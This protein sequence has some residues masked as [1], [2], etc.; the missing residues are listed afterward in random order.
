MKLSWFLCFP[1]VKML[2]D[3]WSGNVFSCLNWSI[4]GLK[5]DLGHFVTNRNYKLLSL[6]KWISVG[7]D[8]IRIEDCNVKESFLACLLTCTCFPLMKKMTVWFKKGRTCG[9]EFAFWDLRPSFHSI[10]N[11]SEQKIIWLCWQRKKALTAKCWIRH[12]IRI[13]NDKK[14]SE[15][16][17]MHLLMNLHFHQKKILLNKF[18]QITSVNGHFP[19]EL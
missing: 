2:V 1:K 6:K 4:V 9:L 11:S 16:I 13:E 3:V 12:S 10:H 18:L 7:D 17:S 8:S 14:V 19:Y 15:I 5:S